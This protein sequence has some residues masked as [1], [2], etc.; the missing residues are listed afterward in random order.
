M[1]SIFFV[2]ISGGS[3]SA[4]PVNTAGS[5]IMEKLDWINVHS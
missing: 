1:K 3:D 5:Q 4:R 2:D